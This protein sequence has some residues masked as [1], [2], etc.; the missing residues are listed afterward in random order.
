M[1]GVPRTHVPSSYVPSHGRRRKFCF[2]PTCFTRRTPLARGYRHSWEG[3]EVH[4]RFALQVRPHIYFD[5]KQHR[6]RTTV[7]TVLRR[8]RSSVGWP[9][10]D[11]MY[12]ESQKVQLRHVARRVSDGYHP[13]WK[14]VACKNNAAEKCVSPWHESRGGQQTKTTR[15]TLAG[16]GVVSQPREELRSG[17]KMS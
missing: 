10:P 2:S 16:E 6:I 4:V 1:W 3:R 13:N 17:G 9:E 14:K 12:L 11:K 5:Q 7:N 15:S 8:W